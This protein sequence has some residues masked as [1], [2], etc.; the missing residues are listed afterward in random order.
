MT[1]EENLIFQ[2]Y[3]TVCL[4]LE[5]T[6]NNFTESEFFDSM[7]FADPAIKEQ[8][9]TLGVD[10]QGSLI[11]CLYTMLVVPK[12]LL[13]QQHADEFA[14]VQVFLEAS[15]QNTSTTYASDSPTVDYLRHIRNAVAHARVSF[16]P[17]DVIVFSDQRGSD[18]F[19]TELPLAK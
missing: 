9:R 15:T 16:R 1:Q 11:M 5:L 8:V 14:E 3:W 7:A 18:R 10:N 2:S 13:E 19:S 6:N 4:L 12:Q 17:N